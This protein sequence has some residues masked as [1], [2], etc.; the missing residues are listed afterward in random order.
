MENNKAAESD[1]LAETA[2]SHFEY[3]SSTIEFMISLKQS[4]E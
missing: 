4:Q 1:Y 3:V 2:D